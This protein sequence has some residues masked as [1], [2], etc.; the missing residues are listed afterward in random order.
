MATILTREDGTY[1]KLEDAVLEREAIVREVLL[2]LK[3]YF[4]AYIDTVVEAHAYGLQVDVAEDLDNM[5]QQIDQL[6]SEINYKK[7]KSL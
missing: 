7:A 4:K 5:Q 6:R 3:P 2:N 1:I